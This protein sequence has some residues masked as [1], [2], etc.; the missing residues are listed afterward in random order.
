MDKDAV[1]KFLA[2]H[3][4]SSSSEIFQGMGVGSLATLKRVLSKLLQEGLIAVHGKGRAT[5]YS[6]SAFYGMLVPIEMDEYYRKEI[7]EREIIKGFNF[8][9][10]DTLLTDVPIFGKDEREK[11]AILQNRFLANTAA[12]SNTEY[13]KERD[14]KAGD[15]SKLEVFSNRGEYLLVA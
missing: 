14:R 8:E 4:N 2:S 15:R 13:Q 9:L 10:F 12:M 3:P 5:K 1:I 11:L 6:L 7:D